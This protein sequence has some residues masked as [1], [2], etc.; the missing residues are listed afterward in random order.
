M[1]VDWLPGLAV[2]PQC[3]GARGCQVL[4]YVP[5]IFI[6]M[7]SE[8]HTHFREPF[9]LIGLAH[10]TPASSDG[11]MWPSD[12]QGWPVCRGLLPPGSIPFRCC[13]DLEIRAFCL[14][15]TGRSSTEAAKV[16]SQT[17][18]YKN[19]ICLINRWLLLSIPG[20]KDL[21]PWEFRSS[22]KLK[23]WDLMQNCAKEPATPSGATTSAARR[24][25]GSDARSCC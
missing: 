1:P 9:S 8:Q 10:C 23:N 2:N 25:P 18:H 7:G 6:Q 20:P 21:I 14:Q 16:R 15:V 24:S 5:G 4:L 12:G 13:T 22:F 17:S 11:M 19:Q 3:P